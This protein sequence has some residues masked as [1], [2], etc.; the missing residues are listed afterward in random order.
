MVQKAGRNTELEEHYTAEE[1]GEKVLAR[2]T[3]W[4]GRKEPPA[5]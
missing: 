1:I 3:G 5:S 4:D 2:L